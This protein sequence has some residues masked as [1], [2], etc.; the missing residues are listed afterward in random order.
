MKRWCEIYAD[1]SGRLIVVSHE[2]GI[3]EHISISDLPYLETAWSG[4]YGRGEIVN[5]RVVG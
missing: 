3:G 2:V 5:V 4:P 1:E